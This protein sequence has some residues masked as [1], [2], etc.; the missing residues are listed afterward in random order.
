M[1]RAYVEVPIVREAYVVLI[2]PGPRA[3]LVKL[4]VVARHGALKAWGSRVRRGAFA[5][6]PSQKCEG[7]RVL[8]WLST[9]PG[10][11]MDRYS[12]GAEIP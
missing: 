11:D 8:V 5:F 6:V 4:G 1:F 2:A 9:K 10:G 12:E 3:I 7:V